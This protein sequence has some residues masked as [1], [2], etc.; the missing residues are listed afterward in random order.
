MELVRG[1]G[2]LRL[3]AEYGKAEARQRSAGM[4]SRYDEIWYFGG[5]Q[6]RS[7]VLR[8]GKRLVGEGA[9]ME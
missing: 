6:V 3:K 2:Y 4:Q 7:Q 1:E 9:L 5:D 8:E